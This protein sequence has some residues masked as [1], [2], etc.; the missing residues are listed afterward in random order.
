MRAEAEGG[1]TMY[2]WKGMRSGVGSICSWSGWSSYG[3]LYMIEVDLM[4]IM[5]R[6]VHQITIDDTPIF[7]TRIYIPGESGIKAIKS[8]KSNHLSTLLLSYSIL[9]TIHYPTMSLNLPKPV[10]TYAGQDELR[11][12]N[13]NGHSNGVEEEAEYRAPRMSDRF[14]ATMIYP[15]KEMRSR[16]IFHIV[17]FSHPFDY[18]YW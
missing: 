8:E 6:S 12:T 1:W 14:K 18:R 2:M 3:L 9:Y 11:N 13:G 4:Y 5:Y 16:S 15:P 17:T 10:N 7:Y